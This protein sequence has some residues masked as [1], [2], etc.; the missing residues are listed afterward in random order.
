MI[1]SKTSAVYQE[2]DKRFFLAMSEHLDLPASSA[3]PTAPAAAVNHEQ[4]PVKQESLPVATPPSSVAA[5][6]AA[7]TAAVGAAPL[8]G[9]TPP[10]ESLVCEW[11]DCK[12]QLPSAEAL[13]VS[14]HR[15]I[16]MS[17]MLTGIGTHLRAPCRSEKHKQPESDLPMGQL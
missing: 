17:D 12:Q 7:A 4:P 9:S 3:P 11:G 8:N 5:A 13:Y 16:T 14:Y 10:G 6:A 1:L 2:R 15:R